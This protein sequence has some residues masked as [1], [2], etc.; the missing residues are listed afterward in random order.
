[1][2]LV[3]GETSNVT[4]IVVFS[5]DLGISLLPPFIMGEAKVKLSGG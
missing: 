4:V 1:M 2:I 3:C 5:F